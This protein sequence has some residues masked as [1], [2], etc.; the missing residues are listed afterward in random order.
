MESAS[1]T[2][3]RLLTEVFILLDDADRRALRQHN[4]SIRQFNILYHL[5]QNQGMSINDLSRCLLCDKSNTTRLVERMKQEGLVTRERDT[6]D[7]RYVSVRLTETGV[8]LR[9]SA[10][11]AHQTSIEE[12]FKTLLP[13]EQAALNQLLVHLRDSLREHISQIQ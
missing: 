1:I 11:A 10:I 3:Y 7:R 5:N 6:Q 9:E 12:R 4:L 13:T 2:L 8:R